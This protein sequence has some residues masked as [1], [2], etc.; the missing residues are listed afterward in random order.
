MLTEKSLMLCRNMDL[1]KKSF[2]LHGSYENILNK[3]AFKILR[4]LITMQ[5]VPPLSVSEKLIFLIFNDLKI[6]KPIDRSKK[7]TI[8]HIRTYT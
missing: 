5:D 3:L 2:I 8:K 6:A 7:I 4:T 1:R